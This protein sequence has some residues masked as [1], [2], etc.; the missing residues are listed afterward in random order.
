MMMGRCLRVM[1][2]AA[3]KPK[4]NRAPEFDS[5][6][7]WIGDKWPI[8]A[9]YLPQYINAWL[10]EIYAR[11]DVK[12]FIGFKGVHAGVTS[13]YCDIGTNLHHSGF[14]FGN[15]LDNRA[16]TGAGLQQNEV[17]VG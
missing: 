7:V 3:E 1:S 14:V 16:G 8:F 11:L 13:C 4:Q 5:K 9:N 17:S 6:F 2:N 15:N 12:N 10:R